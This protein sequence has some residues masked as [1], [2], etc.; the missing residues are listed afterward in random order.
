[1]GTR[2]SLRN[3]RLEVEVRAG[4][5][6]STDGSHTLPDGLSASFERIINEQR[7]H[8]LFV[9]RSKIPSENCTESLLIVKFTTITRRNELI[10]RTRW[11][12]GLNASVCPPVGRI[13]ICER[14]ISV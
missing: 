10:A 9:F 3:A 12:D 14:I 8:E 6:T 1:M 5:A 7:D 13:S 2:S 4:F 11:R